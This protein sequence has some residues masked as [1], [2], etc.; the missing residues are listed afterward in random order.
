MERWVVYWLPYLIDFLIKR[1]KNKSCAEVKSRVTNWW[2]VLK[3]WLLAL[4]FWSHWRPV[5]RNF[6]PCC[7][8]ISTISCL[9]TCK[10]CLFI[11]IILMTYSVWMQSVAKWPAA[12]HFVHSTLFVTFFC[13]GH[14]Q[15]RC[16]TDPQF[17]HLQQINKDGEVKYMHFKVT[18]RNQDK[19][20]NLMVHVRGSR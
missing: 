12:P 11:I 10:G 20:N 13:S 9:I 18:N 14:S 19:I 1:F 4:N 5:S 3:I 15:W 8:V 7:A 2:P 17:R 6:E 16:S